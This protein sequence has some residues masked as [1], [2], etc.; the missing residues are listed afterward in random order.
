METYSGLKMD[1]IGFLE[2]WG[3]M[4]RERKPLARFL[5]WAAEMSNYA[6]PKPKNP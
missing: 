3:F 2:F 6:G 1:K 4:I 5:K